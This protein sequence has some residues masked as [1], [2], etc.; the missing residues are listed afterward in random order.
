M[1]I[2]H[3]IDDLKQALKNIDNIAFVPTMGCL[4]DGHLA[5]VENAKQKSCF[6][7]VSIFVNPLQ[8]GPSEDFDRY[9]KTFAADCEKLE[10]A[11]VHVLF[12]PTVDTLYPRPQTCFVEPASHDRLLEA[13]TRPGHFKGV[14]TVVLKLL[15]LVKPAYAF[16]GKK[17]YQQLAMI[18]NM[19]D[20]LNV[21][22]ELVG[23]ETVREND[24]LAMSS[25]N[26]YLSAEERKTAPMLYQML[27]SIREQIRQGEKQFDRLTWQ[28]TEKLNQA[29]WQ[30]DYLV[31]CPQN[32][33]Q[34]EPVWGTP[35]VILAAAK[36]GTTR[37]I[38][39]LE[40]NF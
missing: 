16:F 8:F 34:S 5:L 37:L 32:Q 13:K 9:P 29:G 19:V 4:H 15:N 17:D 30:T 33:L 21:D 6:I 22:I 36:L 27:L 18:R 24:G 35:L 23:V 12:S 38:D 7:V 28:A 26:L 10:K 14:A 20:E 3:T 39:N 11:G 25:R 40:I 1:I 2:A 31:V